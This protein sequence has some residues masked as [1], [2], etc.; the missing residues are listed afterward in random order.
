MALMNSF[1]GGRRGASFVIVKNY[2]DVVTMTADF[3]RGNDFTEVNYDEYVMINNP[4]KNHPDNGKIFRRGYDYNSDRTLSDVTVLCDDNDVPYPAAQ[5]S[6]EKYNK[7]E[8]SLKFKK[9]EDINNYSLKAGGAEY[10]GCIVGPS[11]KAP[12][13]KLVSYDEAE[14]K[15][16]E[17]EFDEYKGSGS[18][19]PIAGFIPGKNG[20]NDTFN[21]SIQWY[22]TCIRNNNYGDDS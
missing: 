8:K 13:L 4:N 20:G 10:I 19:N 3:A 12:M 5:I 6:E 16:A 9:V 1:Y 14:Q 18:Y 22:C 17:T 2:L 21:D 11:G 15:H 7:K